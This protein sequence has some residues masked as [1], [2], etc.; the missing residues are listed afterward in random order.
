MAK[1]KSILNDVDL[2]L[3][4]SKFATKDELVAFE[5]RIKQ[6]FEDL[7]D[8]VRLL[9]TR[10]EFLTKMDELMGELKA[11]R[12]E[13]ATLSYRVSN[14]SDEIQELQNIHPNNRHFALASNE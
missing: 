12:E 3:L 13:S 8:K 1:Q 7:E 9:P 6:K 2:D 14:H 5:I 10:N 4:E 11:M